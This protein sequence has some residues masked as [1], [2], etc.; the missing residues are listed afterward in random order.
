MSENFL[1]LKQFIP[2]DWP[3]EH[4]LHISGFILEVV[5]GVVGVISIVV[6]MLIV[7]KSCIAGAIA[8]II[9]NSVLV[10]ILVVWITILTFVIWV[11]DVSFIDLKLIITGADINL[12]DLVHPSC[13]DGLFCKDAGLKI[14]G[15]LKSCL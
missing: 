10:S 15:F 5:F 13:I 4:H 11:S 1:D 8:G 12:V 14:H 3:S 9:V 7:S 2:A 6:V